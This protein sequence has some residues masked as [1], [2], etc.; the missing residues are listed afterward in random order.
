MNI[1]DKTHLYSEIY[2][3]LRPGGR[4]A[5]QEA[6]SGAFSPPHFPVPWARDEATSFLQ[7]WDEARALLVETCLRVLVWEDLGSAPRAEAQL[8]PENRV[9]VLPG[10]TSDPEVAQATANMARN[11]AEAR[12]R[13]IQAVCE[14]VG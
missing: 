11:L 3:L 8:N 1:P 9:W 7:S 13:V 5:F 4:Y 6:M 2:R 14:R 10:V 12:I